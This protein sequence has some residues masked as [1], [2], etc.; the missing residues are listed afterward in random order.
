MTIISEN[1]QAD[2]DFLWVEL[3]ET[4][5]LEFASGRFAAVAEG[6]QRAYDLTQK[7]DEYDP[8][9]ASS[10]N[11]LAIALRTNHDLPKAEHI[12]R[13]ALG[14]WE[15]SAHW[16]NRMQTTQRARSSLFH[17]RLEAKHR[18]KYN[19]MLRGKYE[20]LL[21]AG[22][23]GTLNNLAELLQCTDRFEEAQQMYH[24]ALGKRLGFK[25]EQEDGVA[26]INSNLAGLSKVFR[27][28]SETADREVTQSKQ[29]AGFIV[30]ASKQGWIVDTPP[31]F[32]DEG[33]LMAAISLTHLIDHA[34]LRS[35]H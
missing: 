22:Q 1:D 2:S 21:W 11:N 4:A 17:L 6:W 12:Y 20:K 29:T 18:E 16:I 31:E 14:E 8:R 3:N 35:M 32:T 34:Y 5:A 7:F 19:N 24:E 23:A 26:V 33:R 30:R 10:L 15:T 25:D 13:S 28:A 9:R 27:N